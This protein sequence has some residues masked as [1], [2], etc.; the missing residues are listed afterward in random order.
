MYKE[1]HSIFNGFFEDKVVS[2]SEK[3]KHVFIE[4]GTI[5]SQGNIWLLILLSVFLF[6]KISADNIW[7]MDANELRVLIILYIY[8]SIC[9]IID[10]LFPFFPFHFHIFVDI[11]S[12]TIYYIYGLM[13]IG[14]KLKTQI[15]KIRLN[16]LREFTWIS[17][18][19][20]TLI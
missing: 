7:L 12:S 9:C 3:Y 13:D 1:R 18:I 8:E 10:F 15:S 11:I 6:K 5:F 4:D 2:N 19:F 17:I 16:F 14:T 20:C